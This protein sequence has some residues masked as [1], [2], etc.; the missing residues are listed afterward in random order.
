MSKWISLSVRLSAKGDKRPVGT[1]I[2]EHITY[3]KDNPYSLAC[4]LYDV[5]RDATEFSVLSGTLSMDDA[6][7]QIQDAARLIADIELVEVNKQCTT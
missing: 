7:R 4:I 1:I 5:A 3:A 2:G 6:N